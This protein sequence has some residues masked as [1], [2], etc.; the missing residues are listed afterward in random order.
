MI[1]LDH[2]ATSPLDPQVLEAMLPYLTLDYGN[3]GSIH[4]LGRAARQAVDDAREQ[5]A[6]FF[7]CQPRQVIFTSG[8][9]E[10]NN[11]V[12]RGL[13]TELRERG[14]TFV[15]ISGIEHDSV[16]NAAHKLCTKDKFNLRICPPNVGGEVL[17]KAVE[18]QLDQHVGLV[19]VMAANNETGVIN[20]VTEIAKQCAER[21]ILF[22]T[23]AV[24]AAGLV[25]LDTTSVF[26]V[27]F[28][29]VSSH[30]INGPKGVGAVFAR[31]PEFLEPIIAGGA[32][33][34]F[35]F[36]GGTENVAGIVGFAA[37]C[38][39]AQQY[40]AARLAYL[41]AQQSQLIYML[42]SNAE[43]RGIPIKINGDITKISPKVLN[44]CF[45]GIDAETLLLLLDAKGV[46]ASAGSACRS[47][48]SKPS[49]V[50]TAMGLSEED[51]R[52]SVRLSLSHKNDPEE[53]E[54]A[55]RIMVDCAVMLKST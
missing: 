41:T 33:Q 32:E 42:R 28:M 34:E 51:A 40:M 9:T 20:N 37:A 38:K 5:V 12:I 3:P 54:D 50:L 27:G 43:R 52:S 44:I 35:G 46:C 48:E 21:G 18:E 2:A 7:H 29:T 10:G 13:E 22:H 8:G 45:P 1:Y 15:V 19:S 55:A 39:I 23:D 25:E 4:S 49:R 53:L 47:H 36:R 14:K 26:P 24:Q 6:E 30:K 11:M 17:P 16:W 31:N